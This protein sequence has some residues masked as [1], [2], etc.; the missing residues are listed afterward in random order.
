MLTSL[1]TTERRLL[2]RKMLMT[3]NVRTERKKYIVLESE[4]QI[5]GIVNNTSQ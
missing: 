5:S 4:F 2:C 3:T 1:T